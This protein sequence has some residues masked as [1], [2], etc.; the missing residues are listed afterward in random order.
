MTRERSI[1]DVRKV[2][3]TRR[4]KKKERPVKKWKSEGN[5]FA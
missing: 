5:F 4:K 2:K 3:I 1:R